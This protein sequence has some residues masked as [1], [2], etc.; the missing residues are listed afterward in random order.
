MNEPRTGASVSPPTSSSGG[1]PTSATTWTPT[2]PSPSGR[3]RREAY[4]LT[5]EYAPLR[6]GAGLSPAR[7]SQTCEGTL[8]NAARALVV[9]AG[10]AAFSLASS[11]AAAAAT[12]RARSVTRRSRDQDAADRSGRR[13]V[14]DPGRPRCRRVRGHHARQ[15]GRGRG[16]PA[17]HRSA[18]EHGPPGQRPVGPEQ[19]PKLSHARQT[20]Q[21]LL[22][23]GFHPI[24]FCRFIPTAEYLAEELRKAPASGVTVDRSHRPAAAGRTRGARRNPRRCATSRAGGHRLPERR[25]QPPGA[26]Q[27]RDSLRPELESD[28]PRT[29]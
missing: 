8:T 19:D 26:F 11:P 3:S 29:A 2:L 1:A 6:H 4:N 22:A 7:T 14:L 16:Q 9:G 25:R 24:V 15:P 13:M 17:A 27:C 23:D 28:P 18:C 5:P 10:P 20:G 12:L 21:G